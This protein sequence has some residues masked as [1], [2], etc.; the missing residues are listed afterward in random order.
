[1]VANIG[2]AVCGFLRTPLLLSIL[3]GA[4]ALMILRMLKRLVTPRKRCITMRRLRTLLTMMGG[5][6][7]FLWYPFF[8]S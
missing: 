1:M 4:L 3:L 2:I 8:Y 7:F 6:G 5:L